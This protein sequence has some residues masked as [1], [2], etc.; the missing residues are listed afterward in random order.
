MYFTGIFIW[1]STT[2]FLH[3][4]ENISLDPMQIVWMNYG[5]LQPLIKANGADMAPFLKA[6]NAVTGGN[7][8][9]KT[10]NKE[11]LK[12]AI[13]KHCANQSVAEFEVLLDSIREQ[14]PDDVKKPYPFKIYKSPPACTESHNRRLFTQESFLRGEAERQQ[15]HFGFHDN[16]VSGVISNAEFDKQVHNFCACI[17]KIRN[18]EKNFIMN[19]INTMLEGAELTNATIMVAAPRLAKIILTRF[20]DEAD[21]FGAFIDEL[22][23][24]MGDNNSLLKTC[25]LVP[26]DE[27]LPEARADATR[28]R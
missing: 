6:F 4:Q 14:L 3:Q 7:I 19:N 13:D 24:Q 12:A 10:L 16:N 28:S 20:H 8:T 11:M 17:A 26:K 1:R 18:K 2:A 23:L 22:A 27:P 5:R 25:G 9:L 21:K 15:C